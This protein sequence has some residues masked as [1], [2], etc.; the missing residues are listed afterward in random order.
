MSV[1]KDN[2][3]HLLKLGD[4]WLLSFCT[5]LIHNWF[6]LFKQLSLE[7]TALTNTNISKGDILIGVLETLIKKVK[8]KVLNWKWYFVDF[9][10]I[11]CTIFN[12]ISILFAS[13]SDVRK[14]PLT[15]LKFNHSSSRRMKFVRYRSKTYQPSFLKQKKEKNLATMISKLLF[16]SCLKYVGTK[17]WTHNTRSGMGSS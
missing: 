13:L 8:I 10:K 17:L 3:A 12:I 5:N 11:D 15:F 6:L 2:Y 4:D 9:W 1:K 7:L 14:H 16:N